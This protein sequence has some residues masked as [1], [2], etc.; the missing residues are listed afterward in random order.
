MAISCRTGCGKQIIYELHPFPNGSVYFLPLNLDETIHNCPNLPEIDSEDTWPNSGSIPIEGNIIEYMEKRKL[1]PNDYSMEN[2]GVDISL[3][4]EYERERI[5]HSES[6]PEEKEKAFLS[7]FKDAIINL[8]IRGLLFPSPF[9][10]RYVD[11][12]E[13]YPKNERITL[14]IELSLYYENLG[15]FKSAVTARLIQDKITHDQTEKIIKLVYKD[16][17]IHPE[18]QKEILELNITALELR[19]KYY[20]KVEQAI[21]S[22]IRKKYSN[23]ND[24]QKDFPA[25]FSSADKLRVNPSKH[26]KHEHDDVINFLSFGASVKILNENRKKNKDWKI[27]EWDIISHAYNIVDRRNDMEHYSDDKLDESIPKE[28]KTLG[29]IFSKEIIDFFDKIEYV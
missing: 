18:K 20:R 22:F 6:T 13:I 2:A 24:L 4:H 27:I 14:L 17:N 15:D 3:E 26:I 1:L 11:D 8:H 16:N 23:I 21:K 9:M 28:T 5:E 19:D 10:Y 29:Y 7:L 25:L 12:V